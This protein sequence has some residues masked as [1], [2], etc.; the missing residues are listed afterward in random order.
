MRGFLAVVCGVL[1]TGC[2]TPDAG[3]G[4]ATGAETSPPPPPPSA[5]S[6]AVAAAA[7]GRDDVLRVN[8][9][10]IITFSGL[11]NPLPRHEER[12]KDDGTVTPS[13][14]FPPV[15]AAGKT[16][17]AVQRE[18]QELYNKFYRNL[19]VTVATE[20][21]YFYVAGEVK[22]PNRYTYV[23]ETTVLSAIAT[24]SHFTDFANKRRVQLTRAS[25][26]KTVV[27]CVK[28]LKDRK[29]D[30]PVY[31]GDKIDVPRRSF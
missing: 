4:A 18:L 19:T 6:A 5:A 3:G 10:L 13:T 14:L 24:A 9:L 17:L 30:L 23:G 8:D 29:L 26:Q 11:S 16:P 21:R 7:E 28:A 12:V 27:D 20:G 2:S 15:K 31:P 25:G 1:I 22:V